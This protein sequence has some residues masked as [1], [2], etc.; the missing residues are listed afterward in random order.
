MK[1]ISLPNRPGR[2]KSQRDARRVHERRRTDVHDIGQRHRLLERALPDDQVVA[3]VPHLVDQ[4]EHQLA[5]HQV[6]ERQHH[7]RRN[8]ERER[9]AAAA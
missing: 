8:E 6:A 2:T 9:A 3:A 4:V 1:L 7:Q 5:Q